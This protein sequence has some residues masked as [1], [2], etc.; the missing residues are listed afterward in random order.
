[1]REKLFKAWVARGDNP[2]AHNNRAIIAETLKL[3]AEKAALLGYDTYAAY[4]LADTMAGT[5]ARARALLEKVWSPALRR[6]QEE[7]DALQALVAEEGGN[8][9]LAPWDWRYY[10][11]RLRQRV[12]IS[13][14]K[15]LSPISRSTM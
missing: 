11:E 1:M 13:T 8:F 3:R 10:A 4:K 5:P 12:M 7:R 2:N 15:R 14:R 6:A 9:K